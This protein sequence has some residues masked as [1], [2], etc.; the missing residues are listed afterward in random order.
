MPA[1]INLA[2]RVGRPRDDGYHP[3]ATV[4]QAVSLFDEVVASPL[5]GVIDC[6]VSGEGAD[7]TG[8]PQDNLAVRAATLLRARFGT[9]RLGA[10]LSI[11]KQIPVA[12]G[13]AGG[14][15]D[16]AG[17]LL[18]CSVLWD[19][20]TGPDDLAAVAADVGSDVPFVLMGGSAVGTG[21]GER[22]L[23]ALSRG[24]FHWVLVMADAGLSTPAVF[25]RF[26]DLDLGRTGLLEPPTDV[27]DALAAADPAAL[28]AALSNDLQEAAFS[29]APH[30]KRTLQAGMDAG[31]LGG[32]VSG[33][34]PTVALLAANESSAVD[35]SVRLSS[36]GVGRLVRRVAGP[37]PGARLIS[38]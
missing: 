11:R 24:T 3:L 34:G 38:T 1:K 26:D 17:A 22:L 36:A 2:L 5:D 8:P 16:A 7:L 35:L 23:P 12:G 14:S 20:D 29:L 4:Y 9:R 27:M 19:L 13:M 25:H 21:R 30:L 10:Q 33:S 18:A 6:D 15:A 32:V 28:G 31:A 37:V